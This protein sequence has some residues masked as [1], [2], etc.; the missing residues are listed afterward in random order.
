VLKIN[1]KIW[2]DIAKVISASTVGFNYKHQLYYIYV[3]SYNTK[4]MFRLWS[5]SE[6]ETSLRNKRLVHK[7][8][9]LR[10]P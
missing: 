4:G 7:T 1:K 10:I 5:S 8:G 2:Q 6:I 9:Q 3:S